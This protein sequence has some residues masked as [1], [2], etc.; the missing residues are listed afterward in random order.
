M[1]L[2]RGVDRIRYMDDNDKLLSTRV[3]QVHDLTAWVSELT[4]GQLRD[5]LR[6]LAALGRQTTAALVAHLCELDNRRLY[7]EFG[8]ESLFSYCV[9][10]L[11]FSDAAA[12]RR[13]SAARLAA[14]LPGVIQ[15]LADGRIHLEALTLVRPHLTAENSARV[16][17]SIEHKS[18]KEVEKIVAEL[19]PKADRPDRVR[20]LSPERTSFSFTVS[21][22]VAA[23]IEEAMDL[24]KATR[25]EEV[26]EA[27]V[28]A[29]LNAKR[30]KVRTR[31]MPRGVTR[32]R[33]IPRRVRSIVWFRDGGRCTFV[34]KDGEGCQAA[35][36]L[37]FDHI[38]PWALGGRSDDPENI[39]LLCRTHNQLAARKIFGE[40]AV[41]PRNAGVGGQTLVDKSSSPDRA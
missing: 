2:F 12:Y 28:D 15:L 13:I 9:R 19:A 3:V 8:F 27:A 6:R 29:L 4:D 31:A 5:R 24:I 39:R 37:E 21:A 11:G 10:E 7:A 36:Y 20:S 32:R 23:R 17:A 40:A 1:E 25:L 18:R 30:P 22:A 14:A 38:R 35:R 34:G 26:I 41:G 16:L 33:R